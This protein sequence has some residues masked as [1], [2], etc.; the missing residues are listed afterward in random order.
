MT[1]RAKNI[2]QAL[3][4][5]MFTS[6]KKKKKPVE[7]HASL[8]SGSVR[9]CSFRLWENKCLFVSVLFFTHYSKSSR[10][11]TSP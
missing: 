11:P 3:D 8:Y 2:K 7:V 9:A 6:N 1:F 4:I 5:K 10:L